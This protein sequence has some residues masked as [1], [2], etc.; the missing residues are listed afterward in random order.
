[1]PRL[2]VAVKMGGGD[3]STPK[4][5]GEAA[6]VTTGYLER[7]AVISNHKCGTLLPHRMRN[8]FLGL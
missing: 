2:R 3:T 7:C 1:M 4:H 8:L 5:S 6:V